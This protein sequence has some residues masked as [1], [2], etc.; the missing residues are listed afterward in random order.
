MVIRQEQANVL[1][2]ERCRL[3]GDR[4]LKIRRDTAHGGF[5]DMKDTWTWGISHGVIRS[6]P[7]DQQ[8]RNVHDERSPP[9]DS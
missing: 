5:G 1:G 4:L 8:P 3:V 9:A 7:P 2:A 6:L